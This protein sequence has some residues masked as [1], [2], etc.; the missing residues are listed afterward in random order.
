MGNPSNILYNYLLFVVIYLTLFSRRFVSRCFQI[1]K[2]TRQFFSIDFSP[3][4]RRN[5]KLILCIQKR[6]VMK[7]RFKKGHILLSNNTTR[8]NH[9]NFE[10]KPSFPQQ[11]FLPK[12]VVAKNFF[13]KNCNIPL[14]I[15][16]VVKN[17]NFWQHREVSQLSFGR[18]RQV[19]GRTLRPNN[20]EMNVL[21]KTPKFSKQQTLSPNS[22]LTLTPIWAVF[23]WFVA[24]VF[25]DAL[26]FFFCS[27]FLFLY[28]LLTRLFRA[29]LTSVSQAQ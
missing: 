8:A 4:I 1:S 24:V 15:P 9:T 3:Y 20:N 5:R 18:M 16:K 10:K 17:C 23:G 14:V 2:S 29:L 11:S 22:I 27:F 25:P 26:V 28:L 6:M 21:L 19:L 12:I 7:K 13:F